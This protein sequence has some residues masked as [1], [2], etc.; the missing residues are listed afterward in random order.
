MWNLR[1]RDTRNT[2]F[3]KKRRA[4]FLPLTFGVVAQL[5]NS[6]Q[7]VVRT[8]RLKFRDVRPISA[9]DARFSHTS[10][11]V[12]DLDIFGPT[13]HGFDGRRHCALESLQYGPILVQCDFTG[14][15]FS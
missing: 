11:F 5:L 12:R 9:R 4:T 7:L 13:L 1:P 6:I 3:E 15:V 14:T 10:S 8:L 2:R